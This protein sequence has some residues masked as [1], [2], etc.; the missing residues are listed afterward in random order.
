MRFD[1]LKI[2]KFLRSKNNRPN[3]I[4]DNLSDEER[5]IKR[6]IQKSQRKYV[7]ILFSI[8]LLILF[9][10]FYGIGRKRFFVRSDVVV[11]KAGSDSTSFSIGNILTGGNSLSLEDSRYLRTYLESPQVLSDLKKRIDFFEL[12]KMKRPD[13]LAGLKK[14]YTQESE[15]GMFRRQITVTLNE[16]DG[17][18]RIRTL[19]FD[20][21]TSL[22]LNKFLIK[23]SEDFVNSLNQ[24]IFKKQLVFAEEVKKNAK[25][26]RQP[27]SY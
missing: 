21:E 13:Y 22:F 2:R 10:Y 23:T 17:I 4:N 8:P 25:D 9:T 20:S 26:L 5:E 27:P 12:Y 3:V 19:G 18:L 6:K 1:P 24:N 14:G 16:I 7:I 11:R 15:Y